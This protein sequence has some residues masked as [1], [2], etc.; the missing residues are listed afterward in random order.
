[1]NSENFNAALAVGGNQ[2]QRNVSDDKHRSS[3]F[4]ENQPN[5]EITSTYKIAE[6]FLEILDE[7]SKDF[8]FQTFDDNSSRKDKTLAKILHGPLEEHYETLVKIQERGA[9]VF[10]TVNETDFQG[11]AAKNIK[12]IRAA[13][14]DLDGSPLRPI[15]KAP[16]EPHV[17]IES[18]SKRYHAYWLIDDL[19]LD[20]FSI[21]QEQ[22]ATLYHGDTSVKDLPRVMRL[23]G[24]IHQ[25]K[26]PF[27]TVILETS[28]TAPYKAK[29]F[30]KSFSLKTS[31]KRS[32]KK[33][34]E[35]PVLKSLESSKLLVNES[36][37]SPGRFVILCPWQHLHSTSGNTAFYYEPHTN[38]YKGHGFQC[39]HAHC[40]KRS[41][42]DLLEFLGIS[43]NECISV[44]ETS[45]NEPIPLPEGL[46]PV[47]EFD[48]SLLPETT[49]GWIVDI[50][51]RMQIPQDFSAASSL[52]VTS[53][54]I[55]RQCGIF[56]KEKDDWL[57][58][59]NLWGAVIGRPSLLKSPAIAEVIKP[60]NSLI[61]Q[62]RL[63]YQSDCT[64]YEER[65]LII[66]AQTSALK[67]N[68]KKAAKNNSSSD[69]L[70]NFIKESPVYEEFENNFPR[71]KER[72]FK[73][74]D[75]TVAKI[76]EILQEN[77]NG[78]LIHRD[79]LT[80]WLRSLDMYGREGDRA[81]YLE[82]WNGQGG[83]TVDRVGRGTLH[84]PALCL[85]ILG[86]IQPGPL[87]T[88][89]CQANTSGSGDDGLLQRFQVTVWPDVPKSWKNIDRWPDTVAK[90]KAYDLFQ[91]LVNLQI[92]STQNSVPGIR[93]D[94][95]AQ[96]I[97]N[98]W[99]H[100][101]EHRLRDDELSP[102][103]E[104]H[105][106]KY[107]SLMPS[108]ALILY[109]S[110]VVSEGKE[111]LSVTESCA[112][113]AIGWCEYLE[114]H[115]RRLYSAK[116]TPS[117]ESAKAL[118]ELIKKG[119]VKDEF[120]PRDIYRNQWS[121]LTTPDETREAIKILVDFGW[122]RL[123]TSKPEVYILHPI[124]RTDEETSA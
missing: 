124:L 88:Y 80:G 119:K 74:E 34:N 109:L 28:G 61:E 81:F 112:L 73:T 17:I 108:I 14:V 94:P 6:S 72:R 18:S 63:D 12:R 62:A 65:K 26:E 98:E 3:K 46:P 103:L 41:G 97:F 60:L 86:G 11:R 59:P 75:G 115:A 13:F 90:Q 117:M 27:Q 5:I 114:S 110:E 58:I 83:F 42:K 113:R 4:E 77:S 39:F 69:D 10:I 32:V 33:N 84:I 21:I 120:T 22:L 76:G 37:D 99:R 44:S 16:L 78:I 93:F 40:E 68:L 64:R 116:Q 106:A 123:K 66:E 70:Q 30:L 24:F 95:S 49:R 31:I 38:G 67:E 29:D 122:L 50:A 15:L 51:E 8:T 48:E 35:N 43:S 57:V 23:P 71:P 47:M 82:S 102:S 7:N 104:S 25:K 107:R 52:V 118:L 20:Q 79:E 100:T 2:S 121:K 1:M 9:G 56:P 53:S 101:L 96:A 55:G 87:N 92:H 89:V 19:P 54:L 91:K 45:W 36:H 85:S 105:L 111:I